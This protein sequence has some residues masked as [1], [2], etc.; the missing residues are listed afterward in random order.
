MPIYEYECEKCGNHVEVLQKMGDKPLTRCSACKGKLHKAV[1]RSSFQ[2]KGGG[3]Y[4]TD[5]AKKG[6][7]DGASKSS[8]SSSVSD[9]TSSESSTKSESATKSDSKTAASPA[10]TTSTAD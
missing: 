4:V 10:A 9:A 8:K 2:L 1:S 7:G 6:S 3:W 5:Y